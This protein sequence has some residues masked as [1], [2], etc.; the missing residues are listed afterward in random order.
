MTF[1]YVC[2]MIEKLYSKFKKSSGISTDTRTLKGKELFFCLTGENFNG[3]KFAK[4]ALENGA[5]YVVVDDRNYYEEDHPDY[6][7]V[8]DCLKALQ[9]L[10]AF[11]RGKLEVPIIGITGT[12][13]KTTTKELIAAVL[14]TQFKIFATKGNFNN[15][16][17]VPLSLLK[18]KKK[19]QLAVIEMGANQVGEIAELCK[20]SQPGFGIITN[21]G[22][23]HLEGFGSY[24][25][26]K[27]TKLAL[28][29]S[30]KEK[31]G[32][33]F[34][35]FDDESLMEESKHIKRMTYGKSEAADLSA[36]LVPGKPNLEIEY[37]NRKISTNL[38]GEF[39]YYNVMAA[40]AVGKYFK[41]SI[42]NRIR[43]LE[44]YHPSNNR[45]QIEK[46]DNNLLILDAYNANPDSMKNA[47]EFFGKIKTY[48]KTLILG[49]MLELGEFEKT[50]HKEILEL[51]G[52]FDFDHVF[53][54]GKAFG[55]LSS[56]Y[57]QFEYFEDSYKAKEHFEIFPLR[58]N[59]ILL[60]GSRGI[61][62]E[63][64]KDTLL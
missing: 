21:I 40:M 31:N 16:I 57:K 33:V 56:E 3:N 26:I 15:H 24:E 32:F 28:Y 53:L 39:N 5:K 60:K 6:I 19:H 34:V 54:V 17:G 27:K 63:I 37:N 61:Q 29:K 25:N 35:H 41:V 13:G 44:A 55:N 58:S 11:H 64:L 30:V 52:Q 18:I 51:I 8:E 12:N 14:K 42:E 4:Q 45:S 48:A 62:L 49:D 38:F 47:I 2:N 36:S 10:A 59:Q 50:K 20:L 43:A 46:G 1:F 22:H 9:Q 23:A 7:L